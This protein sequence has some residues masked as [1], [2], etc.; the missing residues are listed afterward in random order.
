[1]PMH[2][3]PDLTA[4]IPLFAVQVDDAFDRHCGRESGCCFP[5][6]GRWVRR[7]TWETRPVSRHWLTSQFGGGM[8]M[9][10]LL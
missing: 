5:I 2:L 10:E 8:D 4:T 7:A 6:A 9:L 3:H 1:M